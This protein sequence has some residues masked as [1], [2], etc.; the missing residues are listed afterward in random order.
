[1]YK[2]EDYIGIIYAYAHIFKITYLANYFVSLCI[3]S[4]LCP[5]NSHSTHNT[6][7]LILYNRCLKNVVDQFTDRELSVTILGKSVFYFLLYPHK[8]NAK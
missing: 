2:L 8:R 7:L 1:M 6:R 5:I 4:F 3:V